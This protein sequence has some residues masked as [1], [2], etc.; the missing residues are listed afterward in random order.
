MKRYK[1]PVI[2]VLA[3][4]IGLAPIVASIGGPV[5]LAQAAINWT[6]YSE[7]PVLEEGDPVEWD[8]GGVGAA[9]VI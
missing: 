2:L 1:G 4:L 8:E 6:K 5:P 9:C 7:N 3:L